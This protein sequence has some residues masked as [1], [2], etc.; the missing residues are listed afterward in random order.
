MKKWFYFGRLMTDYWNTEVFFETEE[1]AKDKIHEMNFPRWQKTFLYE[2]GST[3]EKV[4]RK[5]LLPEVLDKETF[6]PL[7][8]D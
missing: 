2:L 3:G 4:N 1:G 5:D 6:S 7:R 8:Q